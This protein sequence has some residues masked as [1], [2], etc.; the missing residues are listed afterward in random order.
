MINN[1]SK[2]AEQV[3]RKEQNRQ[4]KQ[5]TQIKCLVLSIGTAV[6]TLDTREFT[7]K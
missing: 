2:K 3:K 7:A 6:M 4:D 5:K 1:N